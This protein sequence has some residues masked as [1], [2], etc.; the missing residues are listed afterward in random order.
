[1]IDEDVADSLAGLDV[2]TNVIQ[3]SAET[4]AQNQA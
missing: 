4:I 3:P 2:G 1:M